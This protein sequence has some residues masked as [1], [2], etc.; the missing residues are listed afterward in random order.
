MPPCQGR[1]LVL[2]GV[3]FRSL[4]M[5]QRV[6]QF[7]AGTVLEHRPGDPHGSRMKEQPHGI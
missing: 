7:G 5:V 3:K 1:L 6:G 2:L 4:D